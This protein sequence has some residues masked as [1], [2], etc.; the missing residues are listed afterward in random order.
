MSSEGLDP[1]VPRAEDA[2]EDA[3]KVITIGDPDV[4]KTCL[5]LRYTTDTYR[6]N[7]IN[8]V[9]Q[10]LRQTRW[11]VGRGVCAVRWEAREIMYQ[12]ACGEGLQRTGAWHFK[13][14]GTFGTQLAV[15]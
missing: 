5:I 13:Y 2:F 7:L 10:R 9:G 1:S 6:P 15:L 12:L 11:V 8:T 4:G 3:F 14:S